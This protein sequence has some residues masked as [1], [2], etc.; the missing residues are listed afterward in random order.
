MP[1]GRFLMPGDLAGSPALTFAPL[2]GLT[3]A[4]FAAGSLAAMMERRY[5]AYKT[6]VAQPFFRDHFSRLDRQIV[7]VD[8]L[9][10]LDAG[11]G[12]VADL[13]TVLHDVLIAFRA[14]RNSLF[15]A[16]LRRASTRCCSPRPRPII[17][18]TASMTGWKPFSA[19]SSLAP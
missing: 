13:E 15:D 19:I 2:D 3:P 4:P 11:P 5:E 16:L 9:S 6:H 10:A 18:I 12:A 1:P 17:S 7:L 14:G 8:V